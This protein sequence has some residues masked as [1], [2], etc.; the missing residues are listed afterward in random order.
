MM[1][2][3]HL[4]YT[5]ALLDELATAV[6]SAELPT[7]YKP[8]GGD[9][10]AALHFVALDANGAPLAQTV[11]NKTATNVGL[12]GATQYNSTH[13]N[14]SGPVKEQL[15]AHDVSIAGLTEFFG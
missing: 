1:A 11:C 10:D 7:K 4:N 3:I 9:G 5:K 12:T 13:T 8:C 14:C 15:V 6:G 2:P